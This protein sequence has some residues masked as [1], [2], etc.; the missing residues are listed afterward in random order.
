V[1]AGT[2]RLAALG[3]VTLLVVAAVIVLDLVW[4]SQRRPKQRRN[5]LG[6]AYVE[7]PLKWV[8]PL[9]LRLTWVGC[10]VI[11]A[12]G[13]VSGEVN[14]MTPAS[15]YPS[16]RMLLAVGNVG[17]FGVW[18]SIVAWVALTNHAHAR[19]VAASAPY[20]A[21]P[22]AVPFFPPVAGMGI[23]ETGRGARSSAGGI[24]WVLRTSGL[25][26][27]AFIGVPALLFGGAAALHGEV[28]GVV[29]A[30]IGAALTGFV[31]WMMVRRYQQGRL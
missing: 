8:T 21:D 14:R 4:R 29:S 25:I 20:R 13:M 7:F 5:E 2:D 26:L 3:G 19:R 22:S 6:E 16:H 15:D 17:W 12:F 27:L 10:A 11:G 18:I 23:F 9:P 1:R 28:A 31:V 24:G 30:M